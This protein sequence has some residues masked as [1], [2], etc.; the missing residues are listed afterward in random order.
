MPNA[1]L[2][3]GLAGAAPI[4]TIEAAAAAAEELGYSSFWL[5]HPSPPVKGAGLPALA[6]AAR[7]TSSIALGI[8]VIPLSDHSPDQILS[9]VADYRLPLDRF[10][11]GI[12]CGAGPR[13]LTRVRS[14]AQY[15][16]D[17]IGCELTIAALGPRMGEL[18]GQYADS[19]LLNWLNPAYARASADAIHRAARD[20]GRTPPRV[21]AYVRVALGPGSRSRRD[22]EAA[23]YAEVPQYSAHFARM[24]VTGSDVVIEAGTP[25]ELADRMRPW[26]DAVDEAIVRA[27]PGED[28]VSAT[29]AILRAT[30]VAW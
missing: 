3:F 19:V 11:L 7:V 17:R 9:Q 24:G 14:A 28:S 8:G 30:R 13:S 29:V 22:R 26:R 12:G 2:G 18:A 10:R 4:E 5:S 6:R 20:S 23:T 16:R 1:Q 25:M 21:Y 15:L 27:L